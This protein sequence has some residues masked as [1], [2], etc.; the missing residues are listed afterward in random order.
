M[1][2][3]TGHWLMP[4]RDVGEILLICCLLSYLDTYRLSWAS[5]GLLP[6]LVD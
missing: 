1:E 5:V 6:S 2:L 3:L 4:E